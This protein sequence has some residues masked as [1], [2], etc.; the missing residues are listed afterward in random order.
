MTREQTQKK[1]DNPKLDGD[2][3]ERLLQYLHYLNAE[4]VSQQSAKRPAKKSN[5]KW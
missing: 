3:R 1:L 2:E 4:H 5:S